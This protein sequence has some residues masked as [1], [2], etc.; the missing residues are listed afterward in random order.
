MNDLVVEQVD[1]NSITIVSKK[2]SKKKNKKTLFSNTFYVYDIESTKYETEDN[3]FLAYSYLHGIK[4]YDF[5]VNMTA[6]NI[7]E[8]C[9]DYLP[10]RTNANC[11]QWFIDLNEQAK[12]NNEKILIFVHN[13]TYEFYNAIFNMPTLHKMLEDDSKRIFAM[14]STKICKITLD[15]LEFRDSLLLFG[16]SLKVCAKEVGM[17]KNEENKTY[18]EIWTE[19]SS[20][21]DWEYSYNEHDLD[22]VAVYFSKFVKMLNLKNN[23]VNDFIDTKILTSTGMV[24][25]ICRKINDKEYL[26]IQRRIVKQ[27]QDSIDKDTQKWIENEVFR[28]GFCKSVACNSFCINNKVHSIDFASAYP[29]VMCTGIYPKGELCDTNKYLRELDDLLK[30]KSTKEIVEMYWDKYK[31][32]KPNDL[33]LFKCRITNV[34]IKRFSNKNEIGYIPI[35]KCSESSKALVL[36]GSVYQANSLVLSGTELDYIIYRMFYDFNLDEVLVE[37]SPSMNSTLSTFKFVSISTFAVEK[38]VF[39][40]L[41]KIEDYNEFNT[42]LNNTITDNVKFYQI[43]NNTNE[44]VTNDNMKHIH[45]ICG[46]YLLSAKGKLNAQYGIAVQH[47]FQQNIIYKDY[48]FHM[49]DEEQLCWNKNENYL[50]GIYVTAHT[51]F[52][53]L[54]MTAR[55]I[56]EGFDI[57]YFDTDSIKFKGDTDK[58]KSIISEWNSMLLDLRTRQINKYTNKGIDL[59]LSNFGNFD[60]E[61]TYDYFITHGSKRYITISNDEVHTT[62]SGV[63]KIA[64]SSGAT[65]FYRKYGLEALYTEWFGL[66]TLF[67]YPLAKRS[68][69][70]I[71]D[72]PTLIEAEIIDDNNEKQ[73]VSQYSCEGISEKDCGY[74]LS[75]FTKTICP[76]ILWYFYCNSIQGRI[77]PLRTTPHTIRVLEPVYNEDEEIVDGTFVVEDG[78]TIE[79]YEENFYNKYKKF[80]K[81]RIVM[82]YQDDIYQASHN[83]ASGLHMKNSTD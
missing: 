50:Q 28:G 64:N 24:R 67:D 76:L 15:H 3:P 72:K 62:I 38:E 65:L 13:L 2:E 33:F 6:D 14:S 22:I 56:I 46:D 49:E 59:F 69:N 1:W 55:L 77:N 35:A 21:P 54:L 58:M 66:N 37:K 20:L 18:N 34:R 57:V 48:Q 17:Q 23:S 44:T 26:N 31:I 82:D 60:Y 42:M 78:Y 8:F 53:L 83:Y 75:G 70:N 39:K 4:G 68:I 7:D 16:K 25:Y 73:L 40:K 12:A 47:Q 74:L 45:K 71:P 61:E 81:E 11:E 63:N 41:Y 9:T 29:A 30:N 80:F 51:R 32:M 36:N 19:T 43:F 52:R 10:I 27:T 79:K 5:D